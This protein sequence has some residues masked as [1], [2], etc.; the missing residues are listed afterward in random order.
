MDFRTPSRQRALMLSPASTQSSL[1]QPS[2]SPSSA[3]SVPPSLVDSS[4]DS[5]CRDRQARS[6]Y[7][8]PTYTSRLY[9]FRSRSPHASDTPA[10]SSSRLTQDLERETSPG[11]QQKTKA[12]SRLYYKLDKQRKEMDANSA[13]YEAQILQMQTKLERLRQQHNIASPTCG[14]AGADTRRDDAGDDVRRGSSDGGVVAGLSDDASTIRRKVIAYDTFAEKINRLTT[15][16]R[17]YTLYKADPTD[18]VA[19]EAE[20]TACDTAG[21]QGH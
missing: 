8:R 3:S 15:G 14:D 1:P 2:A 16:K 10:P 5:D 7:L 9:S 13:A 19:Q 4:S 11:R 21:G 6:R 18:R 17:I 20:A 12:E